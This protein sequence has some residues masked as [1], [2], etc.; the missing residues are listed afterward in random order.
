MISDTD[1]DGL[2]DGLELGQGFAPLK[3]DTGN[4]GILDSEKFVSLNLSEETLRDV[5]TPENKAL[6][7]ISIFGV[8]D[9]DINT[10]VENASEHESIKNIVGVVG[11]P[12]DIKTDKDFESAEISF[13][14]S[15]EILK[16]TDINNLAVFYYDETNDTIEFLET[17]VDEESNTIKTTVDHFSIY[18]VIDI[19]RFAQSW[20][21]KDILDKLA[22][23]AEEA[24]PPVAEI[25]Q[26]DIVFVIDTTGSMGSVINNVKTNITNFVNTLI[27][28]NVDVRLGLIDYKDLEEDGMNSTKI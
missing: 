7:S 11:F 12:I 4:S 23:P 22:N 15:E 14:I 2:D 21:I 10:T 3:P 17:E 19:V 27:E 1:G 5:L 20:G 13:K 6:P 24:I 25:G 28:N 16:T 18:G 9:F 8:P 26:A